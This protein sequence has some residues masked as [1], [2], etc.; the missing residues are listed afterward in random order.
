MK[1]LP[2][3]PTLSLSFRRVCLAAPFLKNVGLVNFVVRQDTPNLRF[4][5]NPQHPTRN[6]PTNNDCRRV[7]RSE[8]RPPR[9]RTLVRTDRGRTR[10]PGTA[11]D[12]HGNVIRNL[13]RF[14]AQWIE[15]KQVGYACFEVGIIVQ[16][17][18]DTVISPAVSY[19][20]GGN[21]WEETDKV[22]TETKPALVIDVAS[23][24]DRRR[25][26]P[27]RISHYRNTGIPV[28]IV[29]DPMEQKIAVHTGN[30][31]VDVLDRDESLTAKSGWI[32]NPSDG[33]L[34]DGLSIPVRDIFEQPNWWQW[35]VVPE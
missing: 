30:D 11:S 26:M 29:I 14:L 31:Q 9:W 34:L 7:C 25:S 20:V 6:D 33:P 23:T 10:N 18:P 4:I 16:R 17:A 24:V 8:V 12:D 22:V 19:F 3:S 32:D 21:R 5:S 35:Q 1:L 27:Q 28:S 13:S 2:Q 15:E